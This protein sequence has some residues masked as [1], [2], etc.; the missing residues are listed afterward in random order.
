MN[1]AVNLGGWAEVSVYYHMG[2]ERFWAETQNDEDFGSSKPW[3][4][5]SHRY[6]VMAMLVKL[7]VF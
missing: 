6:D 1:N 3:D 4:C 2:S 5:A 7:G